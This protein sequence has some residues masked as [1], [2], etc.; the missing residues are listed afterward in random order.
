M[1]YNSKDLKEFEEMDNVLG[2]SETDISEMDNVLG[3]SEKSSKSRTPWQIT[4]AGIV[5][6]LASYPAATIYGARKGGDFE[7]NR[8]KVLQK[9]Q[10]FKPLGGIYDLLFDL[11]VY[12]K[13]PMLKN[14]QGASNLAKVGTFAGNAA[15]Q[16]GLPAALETYSRGGDVKSG[17]TTGTAVAAALQGIVPP[18]AKGVGKGIE[19]VANSEFVAKTFP[20]IQ[21]F[22]TSVPAEYT[23]RAIQKELE[24]NSILNENFD[25]NTAYR[26][27]EEKLS[28][29]KNNLPS[30][31]EFGNK[32][33]ELGQK[34]LEGMNDLQT[35]SAQ[36][37]QKVL[38]SLPD[39]ANNI[40]GLKQAVKTAIKEFAQG[41]DINP[42]QVMASKEIKLVDDLLKN[43]DSKLIDLHNIKEILYDIVNYEAPS[44]IKTTAL[45]SVANQI[46]NYLRGKAPQ[47]AESNDIYATIKNIVKGLDNTNTMGSKISKIGSKESAI[48]GMDQRLKKVNDILPEEYKFYD[49][50]KDIISNESQI[51]NILNTIGNQ[52]E[53]NPKLLANRTDIKFENALED[54]QNKTNINFMD[55]LKDI[56]A[57]EAL[58]ALFPGQ[59]G[60]SGSAQGVANLIRQALI[61]SSI[62]GSALTQNPALLI[63]TV[64]MSPKFGAKKAV[65]LIGKASKAGNKAEEIVNAYEKYK[66][67]I[68]PLAGKGAGAL[69]G[70]VTFTEDRY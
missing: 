63:P 3:L 15:L 1:A 55:K 20:K 66:N 46:N 39:D 30:D 11:G 62:T 50:A 13:I 10:N 51:Q 8:Q 31:V 29:A 42:A 44:N 26:V 18:A 17:A 33:Y 36:N 64:L 5:K 69:Q 9:Y 70:G 59:G 22:L 14:A 47:Y 54:L 68:N 32:Y 35:K 60:G 37:I 4:P 48:T 19:K 27:I 56:R 40:A 43:N 23:E 34:A 41:G 65:E 52:Y 21:E 38:N 53:R 7:E 28:K 45:K 49:K 24:G 61:G 57:R 16:G 12:S 67:I 6:E 25:A 2:L 58:E